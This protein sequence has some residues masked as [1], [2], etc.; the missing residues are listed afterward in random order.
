MTDASEKVPEV[1]RIDDVPCTASATAILAE[2]PHSLYANLA[3]RETVNAFMAEERGITVRTVAI[4]V[5]AAL[6]LVVLLVC[7]QLGIGIVVSLAACGVGALWGIRVR[8]RHFDQL[9]SIVTND[10]DPLKMLGVINILLDE[11]LLVANHTRLQC[12]RALCLAELGRADEALTQ[13]DMLVTK[14]GVKRR[15]G[16][17]A[18]EVRTMA[19]GQ[20]G[21]RE[22]LEETYDQARKLLDE[23]RNGSREQARISMM[24]ELADGRLALLDKEY[25]H[26]RRQLRLVLDANPTPQERAMAE[27]RLGEVEEATGDVV[28][29]SKHYAYVAQHGG[30]LAVQGAAEAKL[31]GTAKGAAV[32]DGDD[33]TAIS[34]QMMDDILPEDAL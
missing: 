25:D 19:Y 34:R 27:Y 9:R 5:A 16:L 8:F 17:E 30:T 1:D 33:T 22:H 29:A 24:L 3:A 32:I 10:C 31:V 2:P 4:V 26:C 6:A 14:E 18:L 7:R 28:E 20:T 12:M 11:D 13:I 15:F 23:S 21:D